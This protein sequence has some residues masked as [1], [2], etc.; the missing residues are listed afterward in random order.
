MRP[1][2]VI[3]R[4]STLITRIKSGEVFHKDELNRLN[5][6]NV[7][8]VVHPEDIYQVPYE[9]I[10]LGDRIPDSARTAFNSRFETSGVQHLYPIPE[11]FSGSIGFL[12]FA[13]E[14]HHYSDSEYQRV[15]GNQIYIAYS[16]IEI[17]RRGNMAN[18][19]LFE[20]LKCIAKSRG[21]TRIHAQVQ[22]HRFKQVFPVFERLGFVE[23]T[24]LNNGNIKIG[25][26]LKN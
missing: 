13:M 11:V 22:G 25:Y 21:V 26:T 4:I 5:V 16:G 1:E 10:I 17:N 15:L 9:R 14:Y 23:G 7:G 19:R 24:E 8:L 6:S 12:D 2:L 20:G 18:K 3:P